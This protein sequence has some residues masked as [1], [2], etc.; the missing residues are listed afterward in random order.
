MT[1]ATGAGLRRRRATIYVVA[2]ACGAA[3]VGL[4]EAP[5]AGAHIGPAPSICTVDPLTDP[6]CVAKGG[7]G[8]TSVSPKIVHVGQ[9]VT[10]K[11]TPD[12]I[13]IAAPPRGWT[14]GSRPIGTGSSP[15]G[16]RLL[17]C[18]WHK[19]NVP[20]GPYDVALVLS[21]PA[22]CRYKVTS[23]GRG[24][25]A[26]VANFSVRY[27]GLA[28]YSEEGWRVV[29]KGNYIEGYIHGRPDH[30]GATGTPLQNVPVS[31][32]GKSYDSTVTNNEG[33]YLLQ[34]K[35]AGRYKVVAS[36]R[37]S[38]HRLRPQPHY[39]PSSHIV[40]VSGNTLSNVNFRSSRGDDITI[41][42]LDAA[43]KQVTGIPAD[44]ISSATTQID[45]FDANDQPL[46]SQPLDIVVDGATIGTKAIVCDPNGQR[47]WPGTLTGSTRSAQ[48]FS[49]GDTT[50]QPD[51]AGQLK[52]TVYA[53]TEAGSASITARRQG[54]SPQFDVT[55]TLRLTAPQSVGS[56]Q[57]TTNYAQHGYPNGFPSASLFGG[58]SANGIQQNEVYYLADAKSHGYFGGWEYVPVSTA[59]NTRYGIYFY[60]NG[61]QG[62]G[63]VL[64]S[65]GQGFQPL[66]NGAQ[67]P[68][69]GAWSAGQPYAFD[70]MASGYPGDDL[71]YLGWP[72]ERGPADSCI[73]KA[74]N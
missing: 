71:F 59:S 18:R 27:G 46:N 55:N 26:A 49:G 11:L 37:A 2:L 74:P 22:I 53:G 44:G 61:N 6:N 68:S 12:G 34:P 33:Y 4:C 17:G 36:L 39:T 56:L 73:R 25:Q 21:G 3:G 10:F 28:S 51:S 62:G 64:N 29:P 58:S 67:L 24:W 69:I 66:L 23:A 72:Y 60:Q 31:A 5:P 57:Y 40:H 63:G 15:A 43:G 1:A 47:L 42:F 38:D 35:K 54:A 13:S 14:I 16:L 52:L 8:D 20:G 45:A 32:H 41:T 19:K 65:D 70:H 30:T 48:I 7:G 9:V 50:T